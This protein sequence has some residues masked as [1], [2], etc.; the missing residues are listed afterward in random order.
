ML[1]ILRARQSG[2]VMPSQMSFRSGRRDAAPQN[3]TSLRREFKE[4]KDKDFKEFKEFKEDERGGKGR[5]FLLM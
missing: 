5:S 4:I 1:P 2:T 3:D